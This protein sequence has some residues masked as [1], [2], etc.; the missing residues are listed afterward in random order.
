MVGMFSV[1][2]YDNDPYFCVP[3]FF[4]FVYIVKKPLKLFLNICNIGDTYG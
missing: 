3:A 1:E 4:G 2:Y